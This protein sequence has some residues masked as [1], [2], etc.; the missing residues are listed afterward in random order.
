M[1]WPLDVTADAIVDLL[2]RVNAA[3]PAGASD[4]QALAEQRVVDDAL[5]AATRLAVYGSLA[6]GER[7]HDIVAD[8]D[9]QWA[10]GTVTGWL[11]DRGWGTRSGYPGLVWDRAGPLLT[12]QVLTSRSLPDAWGRLDEFEGSEYRRIV[13]PVRLASGAVVVARLYVL[14]E[15]PA[16]PTG[17]N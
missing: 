5:G 7:H 11:H 6:P 14:A 3:R 1:T 12:V 4:P 17:E 10:T 13:A 8:L 16:S 2:R 9:G 15:D